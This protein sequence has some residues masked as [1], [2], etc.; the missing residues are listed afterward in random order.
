MLL[1]VSASLALHGP[2][3]ILDCGNRSDMHRVAKA[4]RPLTN[5]P[6]AVMKRIDISRAFTCY[7]AEVLLGLNRGLTQTPVLVFDLLA[8]YLDESVS[9]CEA[10]RLMED[11]LDHLKKMSKANPVLVSVSPLPSVAAE[12]ENL[13]QL[14]HASADNFVQL[15]DVPPAETASRQ[16]SLF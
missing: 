9:K 8:T 13:M 6:A 14:L 2:I 16:I 1:R 4:L 15:L 10:E 5:D 11:S 7:Q 3:R 12:R